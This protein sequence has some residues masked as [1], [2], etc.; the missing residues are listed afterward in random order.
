[1]KCLYRLLLIGFTT[2]VTIQNVYSQDGLSTQLKAAI[3]RDSSISPLEWQAMNV[4][5]G[6]VQPDKVESK[7]LTFWFLS[8][9]L[10]ETLDKSMID[11][12]E[13]FKNANATKVID[14]IERKMPRTI[15]HA[16]RITELECKSDNESGTG[17][18]SFSVPNL[19]RGKIGF[20]AFKEESGWV[21]SEFHLPA[22]RVHLIRDGVKW[23]VK[24]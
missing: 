22:Y 2:F 17:T 16:D 10:P 5:K 12:L 6:N 19:Y 4:K 21:I 7:T 18:F 11:E 14:E 8:H 1:M 23:N 20:R 9:P 24:Q 15:V 13:V 3:E